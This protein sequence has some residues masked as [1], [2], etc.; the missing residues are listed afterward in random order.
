MSTVFEINNSDKITEHVLV[1]HD[2]YTSVLFTHMFKHTLSNG[3]Y[4]QIPYYMPNSIIRHNLQYSSNLMTQK[5]QATNLYIFKKSHSIPGV[6][7]D[8]ELVI[9]NKNV[10]TSDKIYTC[11]L[12][13]INKFS[14]DSDNAIDKLLKISKNPSSYYD[15][16]SFDF[17]PLI[18]N[19]SKIIQYNSDVNRVLIFTTPIPIKEI[20]FGAYQT[21]P[22]SLMLMEPSSYQIIQ[23]NQSDQLEMKEG[24]QE[25]YD[26]MDC[27]LID[28]TGTKKG[29]NTITKL[30]EIDS[31]DNKIVG[32][33][34]SIFMVMTIGW[35]A[36]PPLYKSMVIN[37]YKN[38][39]DITFATVF[40]GIVIAAFGVSLVIDG[41]SKKYYDSTEGSL[42]TMIVGL[43]V[44]SYV[45]IWVSR[46]NKEFTN[47]KDLDFGSL[48]VGFK[49]ML[50]GVSTMLLNTEYLFGKI[51]PFTIGILPLFSLLM[52]ILSIVCFVGIKKDPDVKKKEKK[53]KGYIKHLIGLI[54]G[55]GS[56]YG[57]MAILYYF[58]LNPN[59][60]DIVA[61]KLLESF[62]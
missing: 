43:V 36:A 41:F 31:T 14:K 7:Y 18:G 20:E 56:V 17:E 16:M 30:A 49:N 23:I 42:G 37:I 8:A 59:K 55:I 3:G 39:Q 29:K 54:M 62:G 61:G 5:Y 47:K 24:F 50:S 51:K 52:I 9:E 26:V 33:V 13:K 28:E 22:V 35:F 21:I 48:G 57:F 44:A 11:F 6:D 58:H 32:I 38:E 15:D 12:L 1:E 2:Y 45:S 34:F 10:N 40:I 27:Q 25:G 46:M 19:Q 60:T 4:L 53:R